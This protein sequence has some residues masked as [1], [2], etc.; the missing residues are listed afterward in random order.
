LKSVISENGSVSC[1][2]RLKQTPESVS[3]E[4]IPLQRSRKSLRPIEGQSPTSGR[5]QSDRAKVLRNGFDNYG[6]FRLAFL[7]TLIATPLSILHFTNTLIELKEKQVLKNLVEV[8]VTINEHWIHSEIMRTSLNYALFFENRHKVA[9]QLPSVTFEKSAAR[10]KSVVIRSF[11][12]LVG[13]DLG[14]FST[15]FDYFMRNLSCCEL[16]QYNYSFVHFEGCG[17]GSKQ[18][19]AN[20]MLYVMKEQIAASEEAFQFFLHNRTDVSQLKELIGS[21]RFRAAFSFGY[22]GNLA[23]LLY[24]AINQPLVKYLELYLKRDVLDSL[25]CTDCKMSDIVRYDPHALVYSVFNTLLM[26][27]SMLMLY[28]IV[29]KRLK[30]IFRSCHAICL[31]LPNALIQDNPLLSRS[32][33]R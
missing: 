4:L 17:T 14:N 30:H 33:R 8:F 21:P 1:T 11:E 15:A 18:F 7:V 19:L 32:L 27:T 25:T 20:N 26:I 28:F 9:G 23:T 12:N 22:M 16:A 3:R 29:L 2:S 24:Y 6:F 10:L 5:T 13:K 31:F